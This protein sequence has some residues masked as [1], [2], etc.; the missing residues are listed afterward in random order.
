M[1]QSTTRR[2]TNKVTRERCEIG[3]IAR[4]CGHVVTWGESVMQEKTRLTPRRG[5]PREDMKQVKIPETAYKMLYAFAKAH[6]LTFGDAAA[7]LIAK[8]MERVGKVHKDDARG[9]PVFSGTRKQVK[10][11]KSAHLLLW[12]V[13]R[14]TRHDLGRCRGVADWP[15]TDAYLQA[16]SGRG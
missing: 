15:G 12:R 1:C 5:R 16:G 11:P 4:E 14:G 9:A 6:N 8:G 3:A 10:I 13:R 7:Y 2:L